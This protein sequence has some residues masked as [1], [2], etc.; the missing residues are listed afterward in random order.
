MEG[1]FRG[2]DNE[3]KKSYIHGGRVERREEWMKMRPRHERGKKMEVN[4]QFSGERTGEVIKN[5]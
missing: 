3:K 2:I 4:G 5:R 1:K